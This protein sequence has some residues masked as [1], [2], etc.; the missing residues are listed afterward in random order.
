MFFFIISWFWSVISSWWLFSS[1]WPDSTGSTHKWT[2]WI[3][4]SVWN[5]SSQISTI[6]TSLNILLFQAKEQIT[7]FSI[8]KDFSTSEDQGFSTI[9]PKSYDQFWEINISPLV[10]TAVLITGT[11]AVWNTMTAINLGRKEFIWV[12]RTHH[13]LSLKEVQAEIQTGQEIGSWSWCRGHG[14]LVYL[15]NV[16]V[17]SVCFLKCGLVS[18][19]VFICSYN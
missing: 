10:P 12:T 2:Y 8:L 13:I 6:C 15:F 7:Y 18:G 16:T 3:I 5:C 1:S 19:K 4:A 11:T 14:E 17:Y 9:F